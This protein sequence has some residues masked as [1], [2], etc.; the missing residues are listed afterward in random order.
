MIEKGMEPPP[1][2]LDEEKKNVTAEDCLRRGTI[3]LFLG[4]A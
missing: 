1:A 4:I 2:P 3:M